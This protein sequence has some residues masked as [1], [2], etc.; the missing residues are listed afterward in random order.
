MQL[1]GAEI[2]GSLSGRGIKVYVGALCR[3]SGTK[4]ACQAVYLSLLT[5]SSVVT[6]SLAIYPKLTSADW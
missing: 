4:T 2:L 6:T 1:V 3:P 5:I